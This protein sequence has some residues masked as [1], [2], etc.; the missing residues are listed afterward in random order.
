MLSAG[1]PGGGGSGSEGGRVTVKSGEDESFFEIF[2]QISHSIPG[3][4]GA[5]RSHTITIVGAGFDPFRTSPSYFC[6]VLGGGGEGGGV[7]VYESALARAV[8]NYHLL[9]VMPTR[10]AATQANISVL[11]VPPNSYAFDARHNA[12]IISL[13]THEGKSHRNTLAY[14]YYPQLLSIK[15]SRATAIYGSPINIT[16][17]GFTP[18]ADLR[19]RY[20]RLGGMRGEQRF[21]VE[22]PVATWGSGQLLLSQA[23]IW[24]SEWGAGTVNVTLVWDGVEVHTAG[25][26]SFEY[27]ETVS[28]LVVSDGMASGDFVPVFGYALIRDAA[29]Y[30]CTVTAV[31]NASRSVTGQPQSA[32]RANMLTCDYPQWP[33]PAEQ[34]LLQVYRGDL[35]IALSLMFARKPGPLAFDLVQVWWGRSLPSKPSFSGGI[36]ISV[37]GFG[38]HPSP[39]PPIPTYECR[40]TAAVGSGAAAKYSISTAGIAVSS[41]LILCSTPMWLSPTRESVLMLHTCQLSVNA[42]HVLGSN[43]LFVPVGSPVVTPAS[44]GSSEARVQFES[45]NRFGI[46]GLQCVNPVQRVGPWYGFVVFGGDP[47]VTQKSTPNAPIRGDFTITLSGLN[48][49]YQDS[50]PLARIGD[51]GCEFTRW[52]SE[53]T[54]LC[55]VP[56]MGTYPLQAPA[57][58]FV[59]TMAFGRQG[60]RSAGFSYDGPSLSQ[61]GHICD[62]FTKGNVVCDHEIYATPARTSNL[63]SSLAA[64]IDTRLLYFSGKD[65]AFADVTLH[66]RVVGT[67]C[68]HTVWTSSSWVVCRHST[69][70]KSSRMNL[71]ISVQYSQHLATV[72]ALFSFDVAVMSGIMWG[73]G[74]AT[75][76]VSM[77]L[78]GKEFGLHSLTQRLHFGGS[79]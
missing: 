23:P 73:N 65:M 5:G 68:E 4:S 12:T 62:N 36:Q 19:L 76:A 25:V 16:G 56:A 72:T 49:G 42:A 44:V 18:D 57:A 1:E 22:T 28:A 59:V 30:H 26:L 63:H 34:V 32:E 2:A 20:S 43:G 11:Q 51:S 7:Q 53:S 9:C 61:V 58:D 69:G 79:T 40:F 45:E 46:A 66:A 17:A 35:E 3:A 38:L 21:Y 29:V 6:S 60:S 24:N 77:T 74:H 75:G 27:E 33:Y 31:A 48:F 71:A 67:S 50:S 15:P 39:Q 41:S 14:L 10:L 70:S 52:V 37:N 8:D 55:G 78:V 64:H 54:L 13:N 47:I